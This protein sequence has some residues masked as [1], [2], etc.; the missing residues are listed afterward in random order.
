MDGMIR[1]RQEK[2]HTVPET[3]K[4]KKKTHLVPIVKV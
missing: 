4:N 2:Q 3:L 1:F